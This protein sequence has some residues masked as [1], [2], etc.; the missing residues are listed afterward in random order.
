[1]TINLSRL[2][3]GAVAASLLTLP[4]FAQSAEWRVDSNHSSARIAIKAQA[5]GQSSITLGAAAASGILRVDSS[6]PANSTFEL[7][8]SPAGSASQV[9]P[10]DPVETTHLS[11][12]SENASLTADGKLKL[13]GALTVSRVIRELHMDAN[14][15]YSGP[16]ETD[17]VV[18]QTTREESLTLPVLPVQAGRGRAFTE[19]STSLN[20]SAEDFPEL[21]N[22]VLSVNW[23]AQAQDRICD[24]SAYAAE[25]YAGTLCTGTA[26]KSRSVNRTAEAYSEAYAGGDSISAQPASLVTLALHLRLAPQGAQVS[27]KTGQ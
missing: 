18:F 22:A 19:V 13:T 8:L 14:E 2:F 15:A 5:P 1:M 7:D 27:A 12:R 9:A 23:P 16:V 21:L 17:R 6:N 3:L 25:D 26:I 10:D 11:F 20:V 4:A 24:T